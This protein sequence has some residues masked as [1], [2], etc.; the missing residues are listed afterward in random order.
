[1]YIKY[2]LQTMAHYVKENI[3]FDSDEQI[4]HCV[5]SS[6]HPK[7]CKEGDP[8]SRPTDIFPDTL[9]IS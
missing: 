8:H 3:V 5:G 9:Y 6:F 2:K 7:S 4:F 1:M